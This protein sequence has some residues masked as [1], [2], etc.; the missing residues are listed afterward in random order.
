VKFTTGV[1]LEETDILVK[2]GT[3]LAKAIADAPAGYR[4]VIE[5]G[6]YPLADG[7]KTSGAAIKISKDI[8]LKGLRINEHPVI[9]GRLQVEANLALSQVTLDGTGTDGGQ[10]FDYTADGDFTYLKIENCEIKNYTKGFFYIN[11]AAVIDAITIDG[12]IIS[13]IECS[14]GDLF[15]SRAG[16]YNA[17]NLTNSTIYN[18]AKSRDVFRMDD[19]SKNVSATPNIKVDHCTFSQVGSGNANYR[20]FYTRFVGNTITFTNNIVTDFNNK[21]GFANQKNTDQNPTL[22]NNIYFNT[23]NLISKDDTGDDTISWFDSNGKVLDPKFKDAANGDFTL[24]N[25]DVKDTKA[26]DPRWY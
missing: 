23:K 19:A 26:G 16:G 22:D 14:G 12:C 6:T 4:L 17:L 20:F 25:D 8:T 3:D 1:V 11:K 10:A 7:E 13:N 5:P 2:T 15:D 21:R 9:Q 24:G 18:S